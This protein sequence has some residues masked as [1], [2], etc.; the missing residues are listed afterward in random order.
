MR[1]CAGRIS[2]LRPTGEHD[3]DPRDR[4]TGV[5]GLSYRRD[6]GSIDLH[7]PDMPVEIVLTGFPAHW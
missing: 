6:H 5:P 1:P 3:G 7:R 4:I 2:P